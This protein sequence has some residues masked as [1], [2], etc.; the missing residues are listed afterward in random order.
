ME[1]MSDLVKKWG[2][3]DAMT[4]CADSSKEKMI[5]DSNLES[6]DDRPSTDELVTSWN[7]RFAELADEV[8]SLRNTHAQELNNLHDRC[9]ELQNTANTQS[10]SPEAIK[11]KFE[12]F[13]NNINEIYSLLELLKNKTSKSKTQSK[14]NEVIFARLNSYGK[15]IKSLN[16]LYK[17]LK[18]VNSFSKKTVIEVNPPI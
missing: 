3:Q 2:K 6:H 11:Q 16:D 18:E 5:S 13:A 10:I 15:H 7:S 14:N 4:R 12:Y 1:K 17:K 8:E 9:D